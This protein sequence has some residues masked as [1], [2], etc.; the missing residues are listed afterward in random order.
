MYA[1]SADG[2]IYAL[3][4]DHG[5]VLW[6]YTTGSWISAAPA[7]GADGTVFVADNDNVLHAI[8][9]GTAKWK[10]AQAESWIRSTAAIGADGSVYFG[11]A[12]KNLYALSADGALKWKY[13]TADEIFSSPA[14]DHDGTVYVGSDDGCVYA[15]HG[16]GTLR[17]SYNVSGWI[18]S[19]PAI[20]AD[21]AVHVTAQDGRLYQFGLSA[22]R[23]TTGLHSAQVR[24]GWNAS[25]PPQLDQI[26]SDAG[27]K[28]AGS[29]VT[30]ETR[31]LVSRA[32]QL[33]NN[34]RSSAPY[35]RAWQHFLDPMP[36]DSYKQ[37][38]SAAG[39]MTALLQTYETQLAKFTDRAAT[40]D[41][42]LAVANFSVFGY[43][44]DETN[45]QAHIQRDT[46]LM[47]GFGREISTLGR[48]MDSKLRLLQDDVHGIISGLNATLGGLADE[49]RKAADGG[50]AAKA[51]SRFGPTFLLAKAAVV[52]GACF[53]DVTV[54]AGTDL[55]ACGAKNTAAI[56]TAVTSVRL[57]LAAFLTGCRPCKQLTHETAEANSAEA[58]LEALAAAAKAAHALNDQ[59]SKASPLPQKLPAVMT[60]SVSIDSL[61]A[62][63]A[64]LRQELTQ[65]AYRRSQS[66]GFNQASVALDWTEMGVTRVGLFLAYYNLATSVQNNAITNMLP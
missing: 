46:V 63:A 33:L 30:N 32:C 15:V 29:G 47:G 12:D 22:G 25:L 54:A 44:D 53:V 62:A 50:V 49:L 16:N 35:G 10:Y 58:E 23:V 13:A 19:S 5:D 61:R 52:S 17:W 48:Q 56:D 8:N 18:E 7:V 59:L 2:H 64:A 45:W 55:L 40:L 4:P 3:N 42:R 36:P 24:L 21:G 28:C 41:N 60:D 31:A 14:V 38:I 6:N 51:W 66:E 20:D 27:P 34:T 11:S 1:G 65:H 9:N 37:R 43:S 39:T 26:C 57:V